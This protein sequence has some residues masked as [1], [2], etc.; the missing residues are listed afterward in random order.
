MSNG[1]PAFAQAAGTD[2][3]PFPVWATEEKETIRA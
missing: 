2:L 3:G 1:A